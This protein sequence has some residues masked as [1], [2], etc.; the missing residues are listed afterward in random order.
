MTRMTGADC[1][2][3]VNLNKYTHTHTHKYTHDGDQ[4][5]AGTL[6]LGSCMEGT[7]EGHGQRSSYSSCDIPV[8]NL[9][10]MPFSWSTAR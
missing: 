9:G 8:Q 10:F 4:G 3:M 2:V 7:Q 5:A 1:A 6:T